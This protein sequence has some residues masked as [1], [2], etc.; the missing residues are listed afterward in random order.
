M[1]ARFALATLVGAIVSFLLGWAI[2]GTH[3]FDSFYMANMNPYPGLWKP[4]P[5]LPGIFV[6][7][8]LYA[9]VLTYICQKTGATTLMSGVMVGLIIM[10]PF[11]LGTDIFM[12]A[13]M[14]LFGKKVVLLDVALN[15][16]MY[17][18]IGGVIGWV[19]GF[20]KSA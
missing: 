2:F 20:K 5:I 1:N 11:T 7:Q 10:I 18:V 9:F 19:L 16:V 15:G 3:M 14:N 12:W 17:A 13:N 6:A 8:L 4:M